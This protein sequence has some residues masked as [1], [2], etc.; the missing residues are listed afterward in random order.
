[1]LKFN[2][3]EFASD[4]FAWRADQRAAA[5]AKNNCFPS[6][7]FYY[8]LSRAVYHVLLGGW[9]RVFRVLCTCLVFFFLFL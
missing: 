6:L 2:A 5:E 9:S 7:A 3:P 4:C 1:M 8:T